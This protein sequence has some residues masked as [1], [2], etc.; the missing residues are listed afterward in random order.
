MCRKFCLFLYIYFIYLFIFFLAKKEEKK[1]HFDILLINILITN[2][3]GC[4]DLKKNRHSRVENRHNLYVF[5]ISLRKSI[6]NFLS[7]S[8]LSSINVLTISIRS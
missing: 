7:S 8:S 5:S 2:K 3:L 6:A 4:V 1:R